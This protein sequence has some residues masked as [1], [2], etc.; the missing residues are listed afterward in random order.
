M[1]NV[2]RKIAGVSWV[3]ADPSQLQFL[4]QTLGNCPTCIQ[5]QPSL[6]DWS[7]YLNNAIWNR[8]SGS[9]AWVSLY[10]EKTKRINVGPVACPWSGCICNFTITIRE[11]ATSHFF[12]S[13]MWF[14]VC[15]ISKTEKQIN[16]NVTTLG[17][18]LLITDSTSAL[19]PIAKSI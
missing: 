9:E 2:S 19:G 7:I 12:Y 15:C 11:I 4:T 14:G 10:S 1:L 6:S 18:D 3:Q 16:K 17:T 8:Q 5:E 13:I